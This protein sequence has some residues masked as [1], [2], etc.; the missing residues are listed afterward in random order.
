MTKFVTNDDKLEAAIILI[1]QIIRDERKR[2]R[3]MVLDEVIEKLEYRFDDTN[4]GRGVVGV[5]REE[6]NKLRGESLS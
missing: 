4:R 2:E 3:N 5:L 6:F 1:Q